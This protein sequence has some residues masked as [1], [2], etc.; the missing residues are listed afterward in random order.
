MPKY[1]TINQLIATTSG[2][3]GETEIGVTRY[4][5]APSGEA[6]FAVVVADEWQGY[7]L[8]TLLMQRL[9]ECASANGINRLVGITQ[10]RNSGMVN[11]A[12]KLGYDVRT[13]PDDSTLLRLEKS[14][15]S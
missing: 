15:E 4:S 6:E 1:A 11:L 10:R 12:R 9:I 14:I 2:D 13:D 5:S 3:H 8:G 7:G